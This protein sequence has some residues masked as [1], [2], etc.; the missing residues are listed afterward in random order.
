MVWSYGRLEETAVKLGQGP[1]PSQTPQEFLATLQTALSHFGQ[2][3]RL[4][5]QIE[6]LR[7][8]LTQLTNLY[9]Q[10]RYAGDAES[11]RI[12]AWQSWQQVKRPLFLLRIVRMFANWKQ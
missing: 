10:R 7:P 2:S 5:R 4:A 9:M 6:R 1:R 11:G 12:K 8:H 3:P